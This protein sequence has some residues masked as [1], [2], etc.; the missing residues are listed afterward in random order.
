MTTE[1]ITIATVFF[2]AFTQGMAGFGFALIAMPVLSGLTSIYVAAPLVALTTL[3]NNTLLW[4]VYRRSFDW[5]V[6][7]RML[8]GSFLGIPLGF[9]ALQHLPT[10]WMLTAL[11]I[12]ILAY[13]LYTLI[14]LLMPILNS[15][16]WIYSAGFVSGVLIGSYNL[17]GPPIVLYG[18][19]QRWTQ[20]K[21]KGN[22]TSFFWVNSILV[23]WGHGLQHR[24]SEGIFERFL[25]TIPG[26]ILG[27]FLGVY[28]SKYFDPLIFRKIVLAVLSVIGIRLIILGMQS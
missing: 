15:P 9:L 8:V 10:A 1:L 22:L 17:P 23:V 28:L 25:V 20:E 24:I 7:A 26:M 27:L 5:K 11:G 2:S 6:V 12:V 21:F 13:A 19:S 3:T 4:T 18:N 14:G 16:A